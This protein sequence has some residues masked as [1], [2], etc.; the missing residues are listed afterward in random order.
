VFE[1]WTSGEALAAH[2]AG[3]W[4]AGMIQHLGGLGIAGAVTRKYRV[5]AAE[6]VYDASG[7]PRADFVTA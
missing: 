1:E 3:P 6:P 5:D 2:L 7:K 4:Y